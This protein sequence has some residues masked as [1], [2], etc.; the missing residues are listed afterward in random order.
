[1]S[2]VVFDDIPRIAFKRL[3]EE[4]V[5]GFIPKRELDAASEVGTRLEADVRV[6]R[7]ARLC[8]L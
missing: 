6:L 8:L 5:I 2:P 1:M 7:R 3:F 4:L